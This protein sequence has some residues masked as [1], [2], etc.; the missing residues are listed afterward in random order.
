MRNSWA[1]LSFYTASPSFPK[2]KHGKF[3]LLLMLTPKEEE[4]ACHNLKISGWEKS[5]RL[6]LGRPPDSTAGCW[7]PCWHS[8]GAS[9]KQAFL[10]TKPLSSGREHLLGRAKSPLI[11]C[12]PPCTRHACLL[13][14]I[15]VEVEW[16]WRHGCLKQKHDRKHLSAHEH[17][18]L[19]GRE[20]SHSGGC[21]LPA[22]PLFCLCDSGELLQHKG[23]CRRQ[24]SPEACTHTHLFGGKAKLP[25]K[26]NRAVGISGRQ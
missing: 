10:T 26:Q 3:A 8:S 11:S 25:V 24:L 4:E 15:S 5:T 22:T 17:L 13:C 20:A 2:Q 21:S 18:P 6:W 7:L 14:I 23:G 9:L 19:P 12:V 16:R 1:A